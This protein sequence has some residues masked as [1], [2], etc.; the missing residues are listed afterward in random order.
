MRNRKEK[1]NH[2]CMINSSLICCIILNVVERE[3]LSL[4]FFFPLKY[5]MVSLIWIY[6]QIVSNTWL[7]L[8]F[9]R[10]VTV[11]SEIQHS[12]PTK[13]SQ[14]SPESVFYGKMF[15]LYMSI[16]LPQWT[17]GNSICHIIQT[18]KKS[19]VQSS[20]PSLP[21]IIPRKWN[22]NATLIWE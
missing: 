4:Y 16:D 22:E 13:A 17:A 11:K 3:T 2:F 10:A 21:P 14:L 9:W 8:V 20:I 1:K 6:E 5:W 12:L 19:S 7:W 15:L 18:K